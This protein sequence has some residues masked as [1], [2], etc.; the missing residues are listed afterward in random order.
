MMEKFDTLT[1]EELKQIVKNYNKLLLK[2]PNA[3]NQIRVDE[4]NDAEELITKS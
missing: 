2:Y 1:I 3:L 4:L